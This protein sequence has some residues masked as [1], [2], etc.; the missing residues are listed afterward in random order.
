MRA[1]LDLD[2]GLPDVSTVCK[3]FHR[4]TMDLW[5]ILLRQSSPLLPGNRV[6]GIDARGGLAA[7]SPVVTTRSGPA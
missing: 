4:L 6:A 7:R 1:A 5:R 3:A 2:D